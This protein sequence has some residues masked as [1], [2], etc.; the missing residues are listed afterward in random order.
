MY[1]NTSKND[2]RYV[3]MQNS[4]VIA[5]ASKQLKYYKKNNPTHDLELAAVVFALKN[6][7]ILSL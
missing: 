1:N 6:L 4:R 7:T 2:L 5:Y 3:L